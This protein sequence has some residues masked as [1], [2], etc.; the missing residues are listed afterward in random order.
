MGRIRVALWEY[1]L[2]QG[3]SIERLT[4]MLGPMPDAL[5]R[6]ME[7]RRSEIPGL[8]DLNA[9]AAR[10]KEAKSS[11]SPTPPSKRPSTD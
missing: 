3:T 6:R 8:P 2:S 4:E 10:A 11:T 7:I 5:R 9:L 1:G